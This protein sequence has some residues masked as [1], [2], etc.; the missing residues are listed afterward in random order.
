MVSLFAEIGF[1]TH[2][3]THS[4]TQNR[5]RQ[6][7]CPTCIFRG[8]TVFLPQVQLIQT[9]LHSLQLERVLGGRGLADPEHPQ[10]TLLLRDV[11]SQLQALKTSGTSG[12]GGGG[13]G[14]GQPVYE[15]YTRT[16]A[17]KFAHLSKVLLQCIQDIYMYLCVLHCTVLYCVAIHLPLKCPTTC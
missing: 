3:L 12:G 4:L 2:S 10:G 5:L 13:G 14:G 6:K 15:L 11:Q 17:A 9:Q 7:R 16:E 8:C 1:I